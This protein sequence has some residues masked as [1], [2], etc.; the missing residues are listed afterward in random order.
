[1]A[2]ESLALL[3]GQLDL[4]LRRLSGA[5][6]ALLDGTV[7]ARTKSQLHK[8]ET[9]RECSRTPRTA[10]SNLRQISQKAECSLVTQWYKDE[11]VMRQSGHG[12]YGSAFLPSTLCASRDE[13]A[14]VLAPEGAHL[15]LTTALVPESLPLSWKVAVPGRDTE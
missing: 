6:C 11:A 2:V 4:L 13:Q 14:G 5:I 3:G 12:G 7:N 9:Y 10:T 8:R 1:M 15:P